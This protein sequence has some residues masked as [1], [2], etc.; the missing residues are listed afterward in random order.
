MST[1][2]IERRFQEKLSTYLVF[3]ESPNDGTKTKLRCAKVP[4]KEKR[5]NYLHKMGLDSAS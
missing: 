5:I 3:E 2:E 1:I 4:I